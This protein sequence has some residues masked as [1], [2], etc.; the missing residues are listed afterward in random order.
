MSTGSLAW[1]GTPKWRTAARGLRDCSVELIEATQILE[2]G[3][4]ELGYSP[5]VAAPIGAKS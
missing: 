2:E 1:I 3:F 5:G 4:I